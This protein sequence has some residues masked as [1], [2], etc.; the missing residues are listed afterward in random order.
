MQYMMRT[1]CKINSSHPVVYIIILVLYFRLQI[2]NI[3]SNDNISIELHDDMFRLY[4]I[5][6]H[7]NVKHSLSTYNVR[8]LWDPTTCAHD[9]YP[10]YVL[11]WPD[12]GS[13]TAETCRNIV[14]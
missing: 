11:R 12:N 8:T 14:N 3:V 9:M 6:H 2:T 10:S 7:A 1:G 5:H 4:N 13:F